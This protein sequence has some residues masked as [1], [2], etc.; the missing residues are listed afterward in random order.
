MAI[1]SSTKSRRI[2]ATRRFYLS[3]RDDDIAK[4][5]IFASCFACSTNTRSIPTTDSRDNATR[6]HYRIHTA[7]S[8]DL[9][10]SY[11]SNVTSTYYNTT[12]ITANSSP[13]PDPALGNNSSSTNRNRSTGS[14]IAII[15]RRESTANPGSKIATCSRNIS[16][17]NCDN[18][19]VT[20]RA[21]S[22]SRSFFSALGNNGSSTNRNSPNSATIATIATTDTSSIITKTFRRNRAALNRYTT[23]WGFPAAA[24][25]SRCTIGHNFSVKNHYIAI[26]T[27]V[28]T[29]SNT[30]NTRT[31][32][33]CF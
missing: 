20:E 24:S 27:I 19:V 26:S 9:I 15:R 17:T 7:N 18:I 16:A 28:S 6:D 23:G 3:T 1:D 33:S 11:R 30:R 22:N 12:S 29:P 8:C 10:G 2:H 31:T 14:T 21:A 13:G 25:N 32:S 4:S 5:S